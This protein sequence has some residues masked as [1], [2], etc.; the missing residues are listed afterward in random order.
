MSTKWT[1]V[2]DTQ[3]EG[4]PLYGLG[5]WLSVFA[6]LLVAGL[7]ASVA[8]WAIVLIIQAP[9]SPAIR[10]LKTFLVVF[11]F[12]GIV[13]LGLMVAKHAAFRWT[14]LVL[15]V[16][17]WPVLAGI[18]RESLPMNVIVG[19]SVAWLVLVAVWGTYLQ[20]SRRVRVTF[21]HQVRAGDGDDM[22]PTPEFHDAGRFEWRVAPTLQDAPEPHRHDHVD[23]AGEDIDEEWWARA[24]DEYESGCRRPGVWARAFAE[25]DGDEA[26]AKARYLK[27][28]A[29]QLFDERYGHDEDTTMRR[30]AAQG[31]PDW[32][33][34]AA[35]TD[36]Q[37]KIKRA[38]EQ[39]E[40]NESNSF[41]AMI[42][43]IELLG[44]TVER[45]G[46][47]L[48]PGWHVELAG[49]RNRFADDEQMKNWVTGF[50]L[51]KAR[52]ILPHKGRNS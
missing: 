50:V 36:H 10:F 25:A 4:H 46:S 52:L 7:L 24:L 49:Y 41:D 5:G 29:S 27:L 13:I 3:A 6:F 26:V 35:L 30:R 12:S 22:E 1:P 19:G 23:H 48:S 47:V 31:E 15:L 17:P 33:D 11:A 8:W 28:R 45:K 9:T 44:G 38:I 34:E 16:V 21:E 14:A 42:H 51:P 43:L 2:S 20:R 39:S 18:Y 37:R 40:S 32:D